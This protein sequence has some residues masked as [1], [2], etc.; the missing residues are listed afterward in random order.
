MNEQTQGQKGLLNKD[1]GKAV[2]RYATRPEII[3]RIRALGLHFGHFAF[4][5][6]HVL[7]ST[8]L[9]PPLHPC[10]L[11]ANIGQFGVRSVLAIAA[12]NIVWSRKNID[13][14][15]IFGAVVV[16]I[17]MLA[18]Q[19]V[20]I[21]LYALVGTAQAQGTDPTGFFSTPEENVPTDV[22]LIF[23][24]QVFGPNLGFFGT[25]SQPMGTPVYEGLHAILSVYSFAMMIIAV[26]IVIY[27]I[28]TVVGEAAQTGTPFGK[29][30]NSLWAP[31]RLV[32]ALGLLVPMSSGLNSAQYLTLAMA[33]MGSGMGTLVWTT[34][35]SEITKATD[36]VAKPA[37]DST[38]AL[39]QRVLLNEVCAASYNQ[40][41]GVPGITPETA[42][43]IREQTS[44]MRGPARSVNRRLDDIAA[45]NGI[46]RETMSAINRGHQVQILQVTGARSSVTPAFSNP[47]TMV[48]TASEAGQRSVVLSWSRGTPGEQAT[49]YACGRISV[50]LSEFDAFS[51]G[52]NTTISEER[53]YW[54]LPFVG[55]DMDERLGTIHADVKEAY[56]SEIGRLSEALRPAATAIAGYK[57]DVNPAENL[58]DEAS[59]DFIPELLSREAQTTQNNINTTI[60]A[61]YESITNSEYAMT[62]GYDEMVKRGW[63][64]A[65]LW[66]G[67]LGTINKKY[68]DAIASAIPTLDTLFEAAEVQENERGPLGRLFGISR[69]DMD[70]GTT[71]MI[72]D[73][74]ILADR[75]F[76]DDIPEVAVG[77]SPLYEDARFEQAHE[78][79][80]SGW[81]S[82]SLIW[83]LGGNQLRQM[84]DNPELDPMVRMTSAGHDMVTRSLVFAGAGAALGIGGAIAAS[85]PDP[86]VQFAGEAAGAIAGILFV[87]AGIAITAGVF[88][89]YILP[90][91]PFVYF[92][93]AVIG[94]VL[95]IFEA[96]IAMP[97]WALAHLRIEGD[98]MPGQAAISG[99]QL[100]LMILIR[101]TLIVFGL[102]GGYV[103]FGAAM[104]FFVTLFN[105]ATA[106]T[107]S[108]IAGNSIGAIGVFVYT[109][110]FTFLAYNIALMC[111]KMIDDVPKGMLRWIGAGVST[112]G[113]SRGDPINGSR[114]MVAG[115]A[116]AAIGLSRGIQGGA[117]GMQKA[118]QRNKMRNQGIDPDNP[119]QNV[120]IVG[121]GGGTPPAGGG[122]T[123]PAGGGGGGGGTPPAPGG[124]TP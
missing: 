88:L 58:G 106:I 3:P 28:M 119:T 13:Q 115:G 11:S 121:G 103:I 21:A 90:I 113:D 104:F 44:G 55:P 118:V 43:S 81:L 62:G 84:K 12:N 4:L 59:L 96:V 57:V 41:N 66:Y 85:A 5:I 51:D 117:G 122:G 64:A 107:Q 32:I 111:F 15:A 108:D 38:T 102:I 93:F 45:E 31:V 18:I 24:E 6:A 80:E 50:S 37:G 78:A 114:E 47:S 77:Q 120:N 75:D 2:W 16:S 105:S 36:I 61:T 33:K 65:G 74:I 72:E 98:G 52:E 17:I 101:P 73:A 8:G 34:F 27:Y 67:T 29:R 95:E 94:W 70:R 53:W 97:L 83:M 86:R 71:A 123:P 40:I 14:I 116:A 92:S 63:G 26:I 68:M 22:V 91:I 42:A 89:A 109:I 23:L 20:L 110:I 87:F 82:A 54:G 35:V 19:A 79:G 10:L 56:L 7:R 49:D 69:F 9:I 48:Q 124:G 25:T 99:Y 112:F 46:S 39:V 1:T 30:F 76:A 60:V 100:L